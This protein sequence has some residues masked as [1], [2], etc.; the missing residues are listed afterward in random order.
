MLLIK[1]NIWIRSTCYQCTPKIP[2]ASIPCCKSICWVKN[3]LKVIGSNFCWPKGESIPSTA[4]RITCCKRKGEGSTF[5]WHHRCISNII[6][7]SKAFQCEIGNIDANTSHTIIQ[8]SKV[9]RLNAQNQVTI[10]GCEFE[11]NDVGGI[12]IELNGS[13]VKAVIQNSRIHS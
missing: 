3:Y 9:A 7:I 6:R 11:G 2:V 8:Y 13:S 1:K 5:I 4:I 10:T 12:G